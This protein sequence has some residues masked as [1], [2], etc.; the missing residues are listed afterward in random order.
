MDEPSLASLVTTVG[1]T[2]VAGFALTLQPEADEL[3]GMAAQVL[4][5]PIMFRKLCD[6][7]HELLQADLRYQRERA[8]GYGRIL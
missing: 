2:A 5:D 4:A 7:V 8:Q 1:G 3:A 6:R